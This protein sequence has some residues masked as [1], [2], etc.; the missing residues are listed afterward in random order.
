MNAAMRSDK[1]GGKPNSKAKEEIE[2]T[3]FDA[4]EIVSFNRVK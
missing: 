1:G 2:V 4:E 3:E